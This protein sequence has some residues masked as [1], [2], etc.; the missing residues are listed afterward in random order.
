MNGVIDAGGIDERVGGQRGHAVDF[1]ADP[2][3]PSD[4]VQ[5]QV[6]VSVTGQQYDGIDAWC[7]FQH[8]D[9]NADV[10]VTLGGAVAALDIGLEFYREANVF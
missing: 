9:G 7:D 5:Q 10:P 4:L 1:G 8:I 2:V 3:V 6:E